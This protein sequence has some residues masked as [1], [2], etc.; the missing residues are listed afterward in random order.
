MEQMTYP[1][2]RIQIDA[3]YVPKSCISSKYS[4]KSYQYTAID[5][6]T[7][8]RYVEGFNDNSTYTAKAFLIHAL[9]YF[10]QKIRG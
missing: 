2:E 1:G 6:F 5:E 7:R 10:L 4:E 8:I 3:K 9:Q